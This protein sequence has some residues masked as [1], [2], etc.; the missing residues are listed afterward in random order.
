MHNAMPSL[1]TCWV[2]SWETQGPKMPSLRNLP[3]QKIH[4]VMLKASCGC[5]IKCFSEGLVGMRLLDTKMAHCLAK[6]TLKCLS[7]L[8]CW[9]R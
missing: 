9:V 4:W 5:Q 6:S 8:K 3:T 7:D 2:L 1:I